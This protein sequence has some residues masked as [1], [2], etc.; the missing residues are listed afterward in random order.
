MLQLLCKIH[1]KMLSQT[2]I[3]PM[4]IIQSSQFATCTHVPFIE[5]EGGIFSSGLYVSIH[6]LYL[7]EVEEELNIFN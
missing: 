3:I 2:K 5:E 1:K 7:E 6:I 4:V